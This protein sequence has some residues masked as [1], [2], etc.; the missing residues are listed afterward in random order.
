MPDTHRHCIRMI[1]ALVSELH[2]IM[3]NPRHHRNLGKA[4]DA[5]SSRLVLYS[6]LILA[7]ITTTCQLKQSIPAPRHTS[8]V[9]RKFRSQLAQ[10]I[11][12]FPALLSSSLRLPSFSI[13]ITISFY[14]CSSHTPSFSFYIHV[15]LPFLLFFSLTFF[16]SLFQFLLNYCSPLD[17][18]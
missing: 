18:D 11:R 15:I 13:I 2:D 7:R 5:H 12:I 1:H 6:P 9:H 3:G 10:D 17:T 4:S 8:T 14:C 16:N